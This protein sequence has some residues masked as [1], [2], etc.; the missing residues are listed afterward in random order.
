VKVGK[1][2]LSLGAK[3]VTGLEATWDDGDNEDGR[4]RMYNDFDST[5]LRVE[6]SAN[7]TNEN[8]GFMTR[9]RADDAWVNG[10]RGGGNNSAALGVRYAFGW[11][12]LFDAHFRATGGWLDINSNV[13]G[14]LGDLD[15]D[16]SGVG[17]RLEFKPIDGLNFGA[18]FRVP[19]FSRPVT[20]VGT[21][22]PLHTGY[23][24]TFE[25]FVAATAFGLAYTHDF[26]YVR[27]QYLLDDKVFDTDI[28]DASETE[29]IGKSNEV[30]NGL[31]DFG[32]GL[33]AIK[34]LELRAEGRIENIENEDKARSKTDLR[35]RA[36]YTISDDFPL[37]FGINAK[38]TFTGEDDDKPYMIFKPK[39]GYKI[40]V[41]NGLIASLEGGYGFQEK[42]LTSEFFFKPKIEYDFGRGFN[43]R[44]WYMLNMKDFEADGKD[45][46]NANT[47]Q[48]DFTWSL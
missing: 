32:V 1:G 16:V 48:F 30:K 14:T 25:Q 27:L 42:N 13:W 38:E 3:I 26:F 17:L 10:Q 8:V 11:I 7:Y 46:L 47:V 9:F 20:M 22:N 33:T 23:N 39:V 35:Q 21:A 40:P 45:N 18:F 4:V 43:V 2:T 6:F 29:V 41:G 34:Q 37:F 31:F 15:Q 12:D 19:D 24:T 36:I 44:L 28:M 5:Q